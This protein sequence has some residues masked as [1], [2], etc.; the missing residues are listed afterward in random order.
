[1]VIG[2]ALGVERV[3]GLCLSGHCDP[4]TDQPWGGSPYRLDHLPPVQVWEVKRV[5]ESAHRGHRGQRDGGPP[6]PR[7]THDRSPGG[8]L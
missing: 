1:V 6:A 4:S 8:D 2:E 5:S 7:R 3:G